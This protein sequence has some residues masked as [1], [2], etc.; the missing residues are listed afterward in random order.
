[1]PVRALQ[2]CSRTVTGRQMIAGVLLAAAL[3][4]AVSVPLVAAASLEVKTDRGT[5]LGFSLAGVDQWHGIP[6]AAPPTGDRRFALPQ[7]ADAW[8][9][10]KP[11]LVA[12]PI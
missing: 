2:T 12:G 7:E 5:V 4:A 1:M 11:T 9:D 10:V 8:T 6:Y 3:A